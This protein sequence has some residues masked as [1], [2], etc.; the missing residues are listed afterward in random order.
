MKK[1]LKFFGIILTVLIV[2]YLFS[3]PYL[4]SKNVVEET[5]FYTPTKY[6]KKNIFN[7]LDEKY[8]TNIKKDSIVFVAN[9][10]I[11]ST[12]EDSVKLNQT[13]L[14]RE[15]QKF[16]K[17]SKSEFYTITPKIYK[18]AGIYMLGNQFNIFNMLDDLTELSK[19]DSIKIY[20]IVYNGNGYSKG[21][22]NFSTQ[23]KINQKFYEFVNYS[24]SVDFVV[25]HSLGT[26]F[27]TKLATDNKIPKLALLAPASNIDDVANYFIGL[28]PF[29]AKP[30][31]NFS[32]IKK[33]EFSKEAN[34]SEN[35][36]NY[37]GKLILLHGTKDENL[38]FSMS[39]KIYKNSKSKDKTLI[40]IENGD[41]YAPLVDENWI[42]LI[43][44][45][46]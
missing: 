8:L 27:A 30:Y 5:M 2:L 34:S 41:H 6:N 28:A 26:V 25:G 45:L 1:M 23:F 18:K 39:E 31:F 40:K 35:I 17:S 29:W 42:K 12:K 9:K 32:E 15:F 13:I 37:F 43:D 21:D 14:R 16:E 3:I 36:K 44:K 33:S 46:R 19:K 4:R 10:F 38:P 11:S 7:Q 24:I 22:S 20:V